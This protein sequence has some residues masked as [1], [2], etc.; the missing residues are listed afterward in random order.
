MLK[1]D[2]QRIVSDLMLTKEAFSIASSNF[3]QR[4]QN[5][6]DLLN[7]S[8]G[9]NFKKIIPVDDIY[10]TDKQKKS[11]I[12][13]T[14]Q[15]YWD[16]MNF[17]YQNKETLKSI[18]KHLD[19]FSNSIDFTNFPYLNVPRRYSEK[20]FIDLILS[21]YSTY[22]D[23]YYKIAKKYFDEKRIHIGCDRVQSFVMGYFAPIIWLHSGYIFSTITDY[24]GYT[25]SS[26]IHELGHAIDA[27]MYLFP[28]QKKVNIYSNMFTEIPSTAFEVGFYDY[29]KSQHIDV[30]GGTVLRN[31]RAA[32]IIFPFHR[33]REALVDE[34]LLIYENGAAVSS[35]GKQ[36]NLKKEITYG[37][38][39]DFAYHLS[40]I[41]K[42]NPQEFLKVL[43]NL[44]TMR[45]EMTFDDA[46]EMT[47]FNYEDF[48]TGKYIKP[49]IKEDCLTLKKR[50]F[51]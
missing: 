43:N 27:E 30:I 16:F 35:N 13:Y 28:Q 41:R 36:Y 21:Y 7:C 2:E 10:F 48:I 49:T 8:L 14:D 24:N 17:V 5:Y 20:D 45:K 1:A 39:Y 42:S 32:N 40:E 23:K 33:I 9:V 47:G 51:G 12:K 15:E 29:L 34:E 31:N 11:I 25:A 18:G 44:M 19:D 38:G 50:Y 46:I 6:F 22:G 26:I 4:E 3:L 37:I